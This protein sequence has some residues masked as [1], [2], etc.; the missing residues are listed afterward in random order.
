M[1]RGA[2]DTPRFVDDSLEHTGDRIALEGAARLLAV[3]SH[4]GQ[5]V[6]LSIWLINLQAERPFQLADFKG[7]MRPLVEQLD[8][9]FIELIDPL[10]ELV[11]RHE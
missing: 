1:C 3:R 9:A 6:G 5:H 11:D 2:F 4:V 7:A 10:S 8:Q